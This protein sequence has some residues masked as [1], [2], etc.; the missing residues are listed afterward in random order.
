MNTQLT[1]ARGELGGIRARREQGQRS[2]AEA[3]DFEGTALD[4][5]LL[6]T[7]RAER[8]V[9]LR[10]RAQYSSN[11]AAGHPQIA[12]TDAQLASIAS[13]LD[14]EIR[15]IVDG[16]INEEK[17]AS[18]RADQLENQI[19]Q[20]QTTL[21]RRSLAEIRL[22][23]L[24][25]D[26]LADQKLHDLVVARLGGLD[27]FA[28]I[29]K[30]SARVVSMAEVPT[31]PSFP[32]RGRILAAGAVGATILAAILAVLLEA[33]DTR[34]R[35]GQR[36]SEIVHLRNLGSIPAAK[37]RLFKP[38][39]QMLD[40]LIGRPRSTI[41]ESFR[42]LYLACRAQSANAQGVIVVTSTLPREGATS[43]AQGLAFAAAHNGVKTLLM[44]LDPRSMLAAMTT[45]GVADPTSTAETKQPV[46][47]AAIR[48]VLGISGLDGFVRIGA[49]ENISGLRPTDWGEMRLLLTNLKEKYDLIVIDC[50]PVLIVEDANWL[51][52]VADAMLLVV[53]FGQTTEQELASAVAR[54]G[55]TYA[56]LIGT[57]LNC[58]D[59]RGSRASEP[60]G[61]ASYPRH[62][63]AYLADQ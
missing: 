23:E 54:L 57:V 5:P 10:Q 21:Q 60:L 39:Q 19:T 40:R 9:L 53:R 38:R 1:T 29:V 11:F 62:A 32:Q 56:P 55:M 49:P 4:S 8:A 15:R 46:C 25:R 45:S 13:M 28:E 43:V 63:R 37:H 52:P 58:V 24:E 7:L 44:D 42:S 14:T 51:S 3:S 18:D 36:I 31:S 59:P 34:L 30:P 17:V 61:A 47:D 33:N 50:A 41:A 20:L 16:L 2:L 6:A 35:S 12:Q 22:R 26:L 27:P 48:T